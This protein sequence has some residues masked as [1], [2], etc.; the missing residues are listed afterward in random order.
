[1][2]SQMSRRGFISAAATAGVSA[3]WGTDVAT[4]ARLDHEPRQPF[5]D[6]YYFGSL[7]ILRTI[8]DTQTGVIGHAMKKAYEVRGRGG[9]LHSQ[10]VFGHY[11][12]WAAAK[13]VPGQP[14]VLPQSSLMP[15]KEVY[16]AMKKGDFL[17]TNRFYPDVKE[18]HDRGVYVV[19]V[20]TNYFR[21]GKTPA[22]GLTPERMSWP[23]IEEVSDLVIDSGMPWDNGLVINPN[24]PKFRLCPSTGIAQMAVYWACTASLAALI[25]S[26]GEIS[27][28]EPAEFYL[29]VLYDRFTMVGA[30]RPKIDRIAK[31]MAELVSGKGARLFAYGHEQ[32]VEDYTALNMFVS[33]SV[34]AASG[35]KIGQ[36]YRAERVRPGDIVLIGA[37]T[38][39]HPQEI[40]VAREARAK[41]AYTV[42]FCPYTNHRNASGERL[43]LEVDD[44]LNTY[45]YET[46]G[47]VEVPGFPEK[48]SP[49]AGLTGLLVHW[50]LMAQ[51]TDHMDRRGE[52][53]YYWQGMHENGGNEYNAMVKPY[54]DQRGY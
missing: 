31:K 53:P 5:M 16:D 28:E 10:V 34:G 29:D 35:T 9:S 48:V 45:A 6:Q 37:I 2:G 49:V 39:D 27:P 46:A 15:K 50:M 21:H 13:S 38:P 8:R 54:F 1:M 30:D 43:F 32:H 20:T 24:H 7:D 12:G 40:A 4:A 41:G 42:A 14:W 3:G 44:A 52:F 51:W 26:K 25:G 33:D 11:A 36:S 23:S 22:G 18:V 17:I 19:G 47:V